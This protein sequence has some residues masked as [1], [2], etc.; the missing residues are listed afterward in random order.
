MRASSNPAPRHPWRVT[1]ARAVELQ[2][3]L[4][5]TV[6]RTGWISRLRVVAGVDAAFSPDGS[7]VIAGAAAWDVEARRVIEEVVVRRHVTF[8]YVPGLLSFR[9]APALIAALRRLRTAYDVILLDGQG[10]AHPR[11]FGLACHVGVLLDRPTIGC[12]KSLLV[13]EHAEP[14][15]RA[16]SRRPLFH[17]GEVVGAALRTRDG[18]KPVY[19]SVGHRISLEEAVRVVLTCRSG[20]RLPAPTRLADALVNRV[21]RTGAGS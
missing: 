5:V 21:K 20:F 7:S 11:R 8:P 12:A 10:L 4:A 17:D 3:R 19:V 9:E 13:G 2:R 14:A 18:V 16:G 15:R 6:I 1:P